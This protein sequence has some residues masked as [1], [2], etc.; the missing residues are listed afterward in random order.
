MTKRSGRQADGINQIE[1]FLRKGSI[2]NC[3]DIV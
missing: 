2:F 3:F 1:F